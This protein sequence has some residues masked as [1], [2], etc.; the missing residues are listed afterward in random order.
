M[1]GHPTA[2]KSAA[3][4]PQLSV[5]KLRRLIRAKGMKKSPS[6]LQAISTACASM[7]LYFLYE[8]HQTAHWAVEAN[9]KPLLLLGTAEHKGLTNQLSSTVSAV[10][11]ASLLGWDAVL[12]RVSSPF[13][14]SELLPECYGYQSFEQHNFSTFYDVDHLVRYAREILNIHVHEN[15]PLGYKMLHS[16]HSPCPRGCRDTYGALLRK[17]SRVRGAVIVE[18]PGIAA[19]ILDSNRHAEGV[20]ASALALKYSKHIYERFG[21]VSERLKQ[22]ASRYVAIHYRYEPDALI[23]NYSGSAETFLHRVLRESALWTGKESALYIVSGTPV[24]HLLNDSVFRE[25]TK[26]LP[27]MHIVDKLILDYKLSDI[28]FINAAVDSLVASHAHSFYGIST[29]SFSAFVAL[30]RVLNGRMQ[31]TVF[32]TADSD[33]IC[34]DSVNH[35]HWQF[36]LSIPYN[37]C[38][39]PDPCTLLR[40]SAVTKAYSHLKRCPWNVANEMFHT[41]SSTAQLCTGMLREYREC[42]DRAQQHGGP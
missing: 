4:R 41:A 14:C 22:T 34:A 24:Q 33:Q 17:Y 39:H 15:I 26:S 36:E 6:R 21:Y 29:S 13:A 1:G 18:G 37:S 9:A 31:T 35:G 16:K 2:L 27:H 42:H 32:P 7:S 25:F 3:R 8:L 12:P 30:H 19:G 40:R 10:Y 20:R 28:T 23:K 5:Q 11:L 38:F